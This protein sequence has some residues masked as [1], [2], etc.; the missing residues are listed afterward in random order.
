MLQRKLTRGGASL[1][2]RYLQDENDVHEIRWRAT[3]ESAESLVHEL[4]A[5]LGGEG[6]E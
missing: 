4:Q 3:E 5:S 6:R 2:K 1:T